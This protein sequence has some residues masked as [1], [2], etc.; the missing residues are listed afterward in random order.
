MLRFFFG[1]KNIL[2]L[3]AIFCNI[4]SIHLYKSATPEK[5]S[6]LLGIW[7]LNVA[8]VCFI[9]I[10]KMKNNPYHQL[11]RFIKQNRIALLTIL[12][13]SIV[14]RF[15]LLGTYPYILDVD[16][17]R[18]TGLNAQQE[19]IDP[20]SLGSYNGYG[21]IITSIAHIFADKVTHAPLMYLLPSALFSIGGI[22][23]TF[24]LGAKI[25][26]TKI[27]FGA[28]LFVIGSLNNLNYARK[29]L[30]PITDSFFGPLIV[31]A[32]LLVH[33]G[34]YGFLFL[35]II[36]GVAFHFYAA[37]RGFIVISCLYAGYTIVRQLRKKHLA[38]SIMFATHAIV[39][40]AIG[41]YI[42]IG[43]TK[44]HLNKENLSGSGN[45]K[46][47]F[48]DENFTQKP[49]FEQAGQ[50]R[51]VYVKSFV[52]YVSGE[53]SSHFTYAKPLLDFPVSALFLVGVASL[54]FI[55]SDKNHTGRGAILLFILLFPLTNQTIINSFTFEHRYNAIIPIASIAA[56]VG[57][58]QTLRALPRMRAIGFYMLALVFLIVQISFFFKA[59]IADYIRPDMPISQD[60]ISL[61]IAQNI[62]EM[63]GKTPYQ[64]I[65]VI[66]GDDELLMHH[67]ERIRFFAYK[68]NVVFYTADQ[69]TEAYKQNQLA[70]TDSIFIS[71]REMDTSKFSNI[72][73]YSQECPQKKYIQNLKCPPYFKGSYTFY[74]GDIINN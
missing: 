41:L 60:A 42:G 36:N 28:S 49:F 61:Y 4:Y 7:I 33:R 51:D 57:L 14:T 19:T 62:G 22:L 47:I 29:E 39:L 9:A 59:R 71:T 32:T 2:L 69:F 26:N 10:S 67:E 44:T 5:F 45:G 30:V 58:E 65:Y 34:V 31:L 27:A 48:T 70:K 13:I 37:I 8:L 18:D 6:L 72:Q 56:A 21:N 50:I 43:P 1:I 15:Y 20:F 35:G 40:F 53:L 11:I 16:A 24:I 46:L 52:S 66:D 38:K 12:L 3:F 55:R 73:T 64:N 25:C 23:L 63:F 68:K 17:V 74:A 54:F